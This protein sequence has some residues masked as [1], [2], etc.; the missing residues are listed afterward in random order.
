MS[1]DDD[2]GNGDGDSDGHDDDEVEEASDSE[3]EAGAAGPT[4]WGKLEPLL[5][6]VVVQRL[7]KDA[8]VELELSAL[9]AKARRALAQEDWHGGGGAASRAH[10]HSSPSR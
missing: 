5:L 3:E 9:T 8:A 1:D 2:G 10:R 6:H 4:R 7:P